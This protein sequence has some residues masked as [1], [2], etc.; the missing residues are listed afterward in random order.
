MPYTIN[1]YNRDEL[2]VVADG[3]LDESTDIKLSFTASGLV[4][5]GAPV[6]VVTTA[7]DTV[8]EADATT[9]GTGRVVGVAETAISDGVTGYIT[10]QGFATIPGAAI[11][12]GSFTRGAPVFLSENTGKLTSTRPSGSGV[13][14]YQVGLATT[15]TKMIIA[16]KVATIL[17]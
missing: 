1:T 15:T 14:V 11:D 6:F 3:T 13:T 9:I 2:T 7:D 5:D 12:G 16:P 4:N 8:R 10:I 17:S